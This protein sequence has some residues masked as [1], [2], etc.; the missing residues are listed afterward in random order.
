MRH[1]HRHTEQYNMEATDTYSTVTSSPP[2]AEGHHGTDFTQGFGSFNFM[3]ITPLDWETLDPLCPTKVRERFENERSRHTYQ[4]EHETN[5][6]GSL[7]HLVEQMSIYDD[8]P[9]TKPETCLL[10]ALPLEMRH[11][12]YDQ[13]FIP[14]RRDGGVYSKPRPQGAASPTLKGLKG[15]IHFRINEKEWNHERPQ[16]HLDDL[17][18]SDPLITRT[19]DTLTPWYVRNPGSPVHLFAAITN[20]AVPAENQPSGWNLPA[21][22]MIKYDEWP[23]ASYGKPY[24]PGPADEEEEEYGEDSDSDMEMS[25][26]MSDEDHQ[27]QSSSHS[28][29]R[30]RRRRPSRQP[31]R[32]VIGPILEKCCDNRCGFTYSADNRSGWDPKLADDMDE[33]PTPT[34]AESPESESLCDE[35]G[36]KGIC[37]Y[38]HPS[39]YTNLLQLSQMS[40]FITREFAARLFFNSVFEFTE[41]PSLFPHFV[42]DRPAVLPHMRGV[43][44][45]VECSANF[46][47]TVTS[48]LEA[49]LSFLANHEEV[50]L[51]FFTVVLSTG[52]INISRNQTE[53]GQCFYRFQ[54]LQKLKA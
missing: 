16:R 33:V 40:P 38:I 20:G 53:A 42:R 14:F 34:S 15:G 2:Q 1:R 21:S 41:G 48:E 25:M 47:D 27:Q 30:Y 28:P 10:L 36:V 50:N 29:P 8:S 54:I 19:M 31:Y 6:Y 43:I 24:E 45:R 9:K 18:V 46:L 5:D 11:A 44:L 17:V 51:R 12:I 37:R 4:A 13:F 32:L 49:M 23:E 39:R 35:M 22:K 3:P 26:S 52:L 7:K